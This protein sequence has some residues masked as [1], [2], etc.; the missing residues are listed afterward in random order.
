M[1]KS[2]CKLPMGSPT[3]HVSPLPGAT[4]KT[5]LP[6]GSCTRTFINLRNR[7]EH[8]IRFSHIVQETINISVPFYLNIGRQ[9]IK[10]PLCSFKARRVKSPRSFIT[11]F[12]RHLGQ[13]SL[14]V[15]YT[16]TICS[17]VMRGDEVYDHLQHHRRERIPLTPTVMPIVPDSSPEKSPLSLKSTPTTSSSNTDP[18]SPPSHLNLDLGE[19]SEHSPQLAPMNSPELPD[20]QEPFSP[21]QPA[22]TLLS[23]HDEVDAFLMRC[24]LDACTDQPE[25]KTSICPRMLPLADTS[26]NACPDTPLTNNLLPTAYPPCTTPSPSTPP[27]MACLTTTPDPSLPSTRQPSPQQT[28]QPSTSPTRSSPPAPAPLLED[29]EESSTR[30]VSPPRPPSTTSQPG[31]S[32]RCPSPIS[33]DPSTATFPTPQTSTSL[34]SFRQQYKASFAT[35]MTFSDFETLTATFTAE[36]VELSRHLNAQQRPKPAPRR[37]DRPSARPPV[38]Y[39]RPTSSDPA[40]ARRLQHL[41]RVSKKRAARKIFNDES[42]GFDGTL[43]DATRF[44]T[45]T[46]GPRS[47][48]LDQLKEELLTHVPTAD[49]DETLFAVPTSEELSQKLRS[50]SNSAPGKDRLEYRHLRLLDPKCEILAQLYRHCFEARDVPAAWKTATTILIHKKNSTTDASNFRPIALMSCLYKLLMAIIAKRIT[51]FAIQHDLLS[52]EQKSARPS[53]GCY[54]HAFLLESIVNDARRQPRPLAL[55]WLDIRNAFGSIPHSALLTTLSH[56]GFP[57][58]LISMI[59]NVYTGATT[60]VLTP[61]GKTDEIPIHSGVKQGCPLSAILFNLTL[62][63]IIRRCKAAAETL[64][65]GP[66]RHHGIS[67]SVLAY[68]DDLVILARSPESLQLL[69]DAV[70]DTANTLNLA[71]R[72]DK[73]ASLSLNKHAPRI[74]LDAFTVQDATIPALDREDHYRYLGVPIGLVHNITNIQTLVDELTSKLAKIEQ[75]LLAPWQK[76]DAIRTFVQ[77][78]LTYALRSSDP[79]TQSLQAYRSQLIQTVRSICSLPNR[80]TTHY[81]FAAK[82]AG[83]LGFTDPCTENHLQTIVQAVKMLASS[84]PAVAAIAKRELRQTVRFA[85]QSE[86]TPSLI[87]NFL[88]NAQDRRLETI[89][90]RTG[91]L[92]TRTRKATKHL[93]V[94][95]HVP[96][97]GPPSITAPNYDDPI[98]A[99]DACRFMHNVARDN[100]AKKL[101]DMRDQGKTARALNTDRFANGSSWHYTGLNVRFKDWRFIHRARLNCIPT[102]SVKSRWSDA[103]PT[104]R[105]CAEIETLPHILCHCTPNMVA[106]T[107]RHDKVVDRLTAAIRSGSI[108]TDQTVKDSGSTVRPDIVIEEPTKVTIIDVCCPFENG[109]EALDEA[110][111]RKEVKYEHLKSHFESQGKECSV[112]GFAIGA[113]GAWHPGNERVLSALGMTPRYKNLFRK[114]CCTDVIQGSTDIYRQ[115][116]GCDDVLN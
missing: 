23:P 97:N 66:L 12:T 29:I 87:S 69:L 57:P 94:T 52:P 3:A 110:V 100:A 54:E 36:A 49:L 21:Q 82:R 46:F 61:L 17:S 32:S 25:P 34:H 84:D 16:C 105:H 24:F 115:H 44:F 92:W 7:H 91:S 76:L 47:C 43:D 101:I 19:T 106:I 63:L 20:T 114:L 68:A 62:E 113:L 48:N 65:R 102:N 95:I 109:E 79:T 88:S 28:H 83:G 96:D 30:H 4:S 99:K 86:P 78:C 1:L 13:Y 80:A 98:P 38:D 37:P 6:C 112:F 33:E 71:F 42:P 22:P 8:L 26:I 55:A 103:D 15:A 58:D 60:E 35:E 108:T 40:A 50:F 90:S 67:F 14:D 64:P 74:R 107:T 72:A 2:P 111:A 93:E 5:R 85:A 77:P 89:R 9:T 11:H 27:G 59:G 31:F 10:C 81:I 73:C 51:T 70:S 41:Y 18:R 56:M 75:S 104:C 39:R 116:L 45:D 53:E